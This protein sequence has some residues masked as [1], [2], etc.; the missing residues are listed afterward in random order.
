M[1]KVDT[2]NQALS[3]RE[4]PQCGSK[5]GLRTKAKIDKH[6]VRKACNNP[7]CSFTGVINYKTNKMEQL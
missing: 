3:Q 2:L 4:C 5:N 7:E 6:R 1:S